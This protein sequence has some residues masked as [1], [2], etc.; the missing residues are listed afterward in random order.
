MHIVVSFDTDFFHNA[1]LL[2]T[3]IFSFVY[4]K[5]VSIQGRSQPDQLGGDETNLRGGKK[6]TFF[7]T[8]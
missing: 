3:R 2:P 4:F 1:D 6:M 5:A 7:S 8:I